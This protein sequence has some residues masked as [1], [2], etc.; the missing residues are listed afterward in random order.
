[1]SFDE[2][3]DEAL[4]EQEQGIPEHKLSI[5][6]R[7]MDFRDFLIEKYLWTT[8]KQDLTR[9]KT[10]YKRSRVTL[11]YFPP[12]ERK[13]CK[14]NPVIDYWE[15]LS[16]DE[17]R[18]ALGGEEPDRGGEKPEESPREETSFVEEAPARSMDD[19][20]AKEV[21]ASRLEYAVELTKRVHKKMDEL[22]AEFDK[23]KDKKP[24]EGYI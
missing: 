19:S 4:G 16:K 7:V 6:D 23:K 15:V 2:L 1:M 14:Q 3:I 18:E 22:I 8:V 10:I 11:P 24:E 17:I 13:Q 20:L 5:Y 21:P 9:V 12:L